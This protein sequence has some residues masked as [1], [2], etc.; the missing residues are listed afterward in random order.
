VAGGAD[1]LGE[2]DER[3]TIA[4]G[5]DARHPDEVARRLALTPAPATRAAVK[6]REPRL[7]RFADGRAVGEG[8]HQQLAGVDVLQTDRQTHPHVS[9][10]AARSEKAC[11]R[12]QRLA[13]VDVLQT[14]RQLCIHTVV[15]CCLQKACTASSLGGGA[16]TDRAGCMPSSD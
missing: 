5:I 12:R 7:Q 9:L 15:S 3:V 13:S 16:R 11:H 6:R 2:V 14:D 1:G 4:V 8:L 10:T